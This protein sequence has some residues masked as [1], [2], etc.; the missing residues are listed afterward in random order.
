MK[1]IE[2]VPDEDYSTHRITENTIAVYVSNG[3]MNYTLIYVTML[4]I[5]MTLMIVI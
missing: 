2:L 4:E 5:K 1:R 3:N